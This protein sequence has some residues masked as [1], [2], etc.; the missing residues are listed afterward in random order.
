MELSIHDPEFYGEVYVTD[1][2]RQT[3]NYH[4]FC[5]GIDFEDSHFLSTEHALH[6]KRRKPLE[7]FF[8]R[9]GVTRLQPI[10]AEVASHFESRLRALRGTGT[11]IRLD[12]ALAAFS[13]DVIGSICLGND[14]GD[15]FLDEPDFSPDW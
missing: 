4:A 15:R 11:V 13:G 1:N 12:H 2:K 7:P 10:I 5:Q 6:R 3:N 14:R 8:S 9:M